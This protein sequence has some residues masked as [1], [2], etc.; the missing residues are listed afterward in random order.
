[1]LLYQQTSWIFTC[2]HPLLSQ[3]LQLSYNSL[4]FIQLNM[5]RLAKQYKPVA[6]RLHLYDKHSG[7][8]THD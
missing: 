7:H 3:S 1:M 6:T 4:I 5:N 8:E 2:L